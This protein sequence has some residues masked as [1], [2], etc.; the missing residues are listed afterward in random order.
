MEMSAVVIDDPRNFV[1]RAPVC[2]DT[3]A[4]L[5]IERLSMLEELVPAAETVGK[6]RS[7]FLLGSVEAL[8]DGLSGDAK[9][10]GEDAWGGEATLNVDVLD[11]A[12]TSGQHELPRSIEKLDGAE[13]F[14]MAEGWFTVM[15]ED[16]DDIGSEMRGDDFVEVQKGEAAKR[17][18]HLTDG[19][20]T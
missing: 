16:S 5:L 15:S 3:E 8:T 19:G 2:V 7:P 6:Q 18:Q 11:G 20:L 13:V 9:I 4:A 12:A 17:R 10:D 14:D 1:D